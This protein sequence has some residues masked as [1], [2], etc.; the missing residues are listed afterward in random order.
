MTQEAAWVEE[1]ARKQPV[2]IVARDD[3]ATVEVSGQDQ[4][5]ARIAA[6]SPDSRVVRAQ[7]ANVPVARR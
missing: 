5:I 1:R 7:D 3:L 6:R 4:V 2:S